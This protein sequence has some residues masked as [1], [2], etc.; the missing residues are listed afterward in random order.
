MSIKNYHEILPKEDFYEIL[1]YIRYI[2]ISIDWICGITLHSICVMRKILI[3]ITSTLIL[4]GIVG[5]VL[6]AGKKPIIDV[7]TLTSSSNDPIENID[8]ASPYQE[9]KMSIEEENN[10]NIE[11]YN[12]AIKTK[13]PKLCDAITDANKKIECH[14]IIIS[15]E[16]QKT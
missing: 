11:Q 15:A 2:H 6:L 13:N 10:Q 14:D 9:M 4:L 7:E 16:A 5:Y 12:A 3:I 1:S 8:S